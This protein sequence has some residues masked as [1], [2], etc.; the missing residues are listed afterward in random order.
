[1]NINKVS[2]SIFISVSIL[3]LNFSCLTPNRSSG[4]DQ[5]MMC[6]ICADDFKCQPT[7]ISG[8]VYCYF[9]E[10]SSVNF[11]I[12]E[13]WGMCFVTGDNIA[14]PTI[15]IAYS[16]VDLDCVNGKPLINTDPKAKKIIQEGIYA[17]VFPI[18]FECSQE[19][20]KQYPRIFDNGLMLEVQLEITATN[21]NAKVNECKIKEWPSDLDQKDRDCFKKAFEGVT[22]D[23]KCDFA[24][25]IEYPVLISSLS[26]N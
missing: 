3:V 14:Q 2:L 20:S 18:V 25:T 21:G 6:V 16:E 7:E 17:Q 23:S 8:G 19:W 15:G 26:T 5:P 1:M 13:T 11:P 9:R 24:F 12:C 4:K 22:F 10:S